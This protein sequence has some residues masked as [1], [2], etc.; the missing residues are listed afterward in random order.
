MKNIFHRRATRR[1][2]EGIMAAWRPMMVAV[3]RCRPLSS[4]QYDDEKNSVC[5][6]YIIAGMESNFTAQ[7]IEM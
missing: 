2:G 4:T 3:K 6:H 1:R 5:Y 7:V